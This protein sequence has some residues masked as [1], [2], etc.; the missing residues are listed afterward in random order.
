MLSNSLLTI[1]INVPTDPV[2]QR[3]YGPPASRL[4]STTVLYKAC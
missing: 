1:V 3:P 2:L 4:T